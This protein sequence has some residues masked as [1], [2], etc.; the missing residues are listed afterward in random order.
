MRKLMILILM[1]S[2]IVLLGFKEFE[3]AI[4]FKSQGFERMHT[5]AY[6]LH[7]ITASGGTTRPGIAACNPH[8]GE[9]ALIYTLDGEYLGMY[10][11][12]DAGT[13][14]RLV[15]GTS[16]DVWHDN[17]DECQEWMETTGGEIWVMWI[18]GDG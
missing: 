3:T 13:N 1:V 6:C 8:I 11:V 4:D 16:I 17:L 12:T 14:D 9:V 10:E 2:V 7:G 5:T 18:K 15:R